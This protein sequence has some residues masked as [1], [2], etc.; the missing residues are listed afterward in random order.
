MRIRR[1]LFENATVVLPGQARPRFSVLV[2]DG[3]IQTV[4]PREQLNDQVVEERIDLGGDFLAPGFID[5]HIH[6]TGFY[7]VD[8]GPDALAGL[9]GLLPKYGVTGFLPT[10]A[11]RRP[12][13]DAEFLASLAN[14]EP[15]GARV[16]GFHL[17]GP[18]LTL[19]GALPREALGNA[20]PRRVERLIEACRPYS[21]I[22]S[23]SPDFEGIL[24][25]L[26]IMAAGGTP[27][28]MTH[29]RASVQQ[30]E[31]AIE[32]GVR[33]ATHFYNVFPVPPEPEPG[34]RPCGAV[35]V[36]LADPRVSVDFIL[37]GEHVAP[38]ACRMA[39]ACKG[40]DGVALITDANVGAGLP[41][42]RRPYRFAGY[43]VTFAYQGGPARM[44]DDG[45]IPGALAGSGLTMDAALRNAIRMLGLD[46][47]QGVAML[48]A[49]PA[50]ILGLGDR[51]GRIAPGFDA[52]L[53]Q[54]DADLRVKQ[55]WIGGHPQL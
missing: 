9:C 2:E 14:A 54:L 6:G 33:H 28:F 5:L 36:V 50:R 7:L 26:P 44:G 38:V 34:V 8:D 30:T 22:F 46:L 43:D 20:D 47:W 1:R 45:P 37:D 23:V 13:E 15:D 41:P 42:Q 55:T 3:V 11:P 53:V 40:I 51:K 17:E 19:T 39:L 18:F 10:V 4:A 24:E 21:A 16:L 35:E 12:D 29:T 49:T 27:V 32:A 25:L 52:D 48:S 31:A